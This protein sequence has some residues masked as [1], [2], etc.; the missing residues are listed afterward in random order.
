MSHMLLRTKRKQPEQLVR[1]VLHQRQ[2]AKPFSTNSS[3]RSISLVHPSAA[4]QQHQMLPASCAAHTTISM[5]HVMPSIRNSRTLHTWPDMAPTK[6]H[7]LLLTLLLVP[8]PPQAACV[9]APRRG[10]LPDSR[11]S[12]PTPPPPLACPPRAGPIPISNSGW[13]A[14]P[15]GGPQTNGRARPPRRTTTTTTW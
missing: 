4:S 9:I 5:V 12:S 15:R 7:H 8:Q 13:R 6:Y 10:T 1:R 3:F 2:P 14:T 11:A